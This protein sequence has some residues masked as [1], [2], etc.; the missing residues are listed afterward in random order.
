MVAVPPPSRGIYN[1]KLANIF[2]AAALAVSAGVG[3]P[4]FVEAQ[5]YRDYGAYDPCLAYKRHVTNQ[6][7]VTGGVLGAV[8]GSAI[9]GRHNRLAGAVLGAGAGAV[10]GHEIA[11]HS[12]RCAAYPVRYRPHPHCHWVVENGAAFEI[13]RGADGIWRPSGRS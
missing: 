11:S 2:V 8:V 6:G 9:A 4:Q 7:T 13:C 3:V 10:A 12:V 1:L 5:A